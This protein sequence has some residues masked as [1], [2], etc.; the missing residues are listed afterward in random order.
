[1][2]ETHDWHRFGDWHE[3][4][5]ALCI[6]QGYLDNLALAEKLCAANG[7]PTHSAFETA[8]K[9]LRNW[10]AG[11][12]LPQRKNFALLGRILEIDRHEGVRQRWNA[13]YRESRIKPVAVEPEVVSEGAEDRASTRALWPVAAGVACIGIALVGVLLFWPR[14]VDDP[15]GSY[16]GVVA[17]YV[18]NVS[19]RVGDA[20]IIHGARGNECGPAPSWEEAMPLLPELVTGRLSDGGVGTRFSR[21]CGGRVPARAILFTATAAGT[22]QIDLYGDP[23]VIRVSE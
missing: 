13:L 2:I 1:M 19:I 21:Q 20:T 16:D 17:E 14:E 15:V 10:R 11:V 12:H 23:I 7:N 22:E 4:F 9:N 5:D 6:E 18:R 3:L 8:V